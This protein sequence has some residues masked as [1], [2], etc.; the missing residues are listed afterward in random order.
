[1]TKPKCY[2]CDKKPSK[3]EYGFFCTKKCAAN[4]GIM[5]AAESHIDINEDGKWSLPS[6]CTACDN[7]DNECE[8]SERE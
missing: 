8:C 7:P 5:M 3:E 1:M 2:Y 4:Y 6:Y